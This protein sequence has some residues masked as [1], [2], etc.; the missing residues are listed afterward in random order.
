MKVK[1]SR[2]AQSVL[3]SVLVAAFLLSVIAFLFF[4]AHLQK[5]SAWRGYYTLVVSDRVSSRLI[6]DALSREG[7]QDVVAASTATVTFTDFSGMQSVSISD[8]P[9]RFD[10]V[11]PRIDPFMKRV[12]GLFHTSVDGRSMQILYIPLRSSLTGLPG[13]GIVRVNALVH[14]ALD[15]LHIDWHILEWDG[16]RR[17]LFVLSF[18]LFLTLVVV[19]TRRYRLAVFLGALP[20]LSGP[21]SGGYGGFAASC[22]LLFA[23]AFLLEEAVPAAERKSFGRVAGH[24]TGRSTAGLGIRIAFYATVAVVAAVL[25][26][27]ASEVLVSLLRV[28]PGLVGTASLGFLIVW[29]GRRRRQSREHATFIPVRILQ[30]SM[31]RAIRG[32][33][34]TVVPLLLFLLILPPVLLLLLP[35]S[36]Q[37]YVPRPEPVA[38]VHG[39]GWSDLDRIWKQRDSRGLPDLSDYIAHRAYQDAF[40]Y[41][42]PFAFPH[43]GEE[44]TIPQYNF[45][46]RT[47]TEH[48]QVMLTFTPAWFRLQMQ[49]GSRLLSLLA[50]PGGATRVVR[51]PA[52]RLYSDY[53]VL[54]RHTIIVLF[55]FLPFLVSLIRLSMQMRSGLRDTIIRKR[56]LEA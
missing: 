21:L 5:N 22:V 30:P 4:P 31:L 29:Y 44:V 3:I 24:E 11:D 9:S 50:A 23:W 28:I 25:Q 32:S 13:L 52:G 17:L 12:G 33:Y 15:P 20:W 8:I 54:V 16:L 39:L 34:T 10:P 6:V 1:L 35:G 18:A 47:V 14:R 51:E 36:S 55:V 7:L 53:A 40:Q 43:P 27:D 42:R 37:V 56:R 45:D 46:G 41:H 38:G 2:P 19:R 26:Y 48:P 49:T